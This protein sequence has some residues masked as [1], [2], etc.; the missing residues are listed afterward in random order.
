VRG[1]ARAILCTLGLLLAVSTTGCVGNESYPNKLRPPAPLTVSVFIGEDQIAISPRPFG[2]GPARFI[3][4]NQTGTRQNV[5][6]STDEFDRE[7]PVGKG[8]TVNFK[9]TVKPG[10]LSISADN[11]AA[12]SMTIDVGPERPSAQ[13]DLN[14]P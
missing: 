8:Q 6:I 2:A 3:I 5:L 4:V 9:Q 14:L 11:T 13:Q 10:E 7:T 1:T 12:D